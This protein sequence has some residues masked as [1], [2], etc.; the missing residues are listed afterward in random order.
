MTPIRSTPLAGAR[1]F[2]A[3]GLAAFGLAAFGLAAL[4][5]AGTPAFAEMSVEVGGAPMYASRTI[6]EN[7]ANSKDHAIFVTALKASDLAGTLE[8]AGPFTVFAPIN[9]AFDKLPKGT[10]ESL[11]K[12]ENRAA[13]TALLAY[14]V[15]AGKYSAADL[16]A[17]IKTG[18]GKA[19]FKTLQ[20]EEITVVQDGRNIELIDSK[21]GK[22]AV[23]ISDVNQKNGAIHVV[24]AVLLPK[25]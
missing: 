11:L 8:G 4:G 12:P 6:L 24:D 5:P 25:S 14:H 16:I 17:A 23:T 15:L 13:L 19:V 18:G 2:A 20:G 7:A 10:L 9:R 22:S 21:G 3:L 1:A